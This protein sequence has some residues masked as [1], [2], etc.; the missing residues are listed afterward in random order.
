MRFGELFGM[1]REAAPAT[2]ARAFATTGSGCGRATELHLTDEA[3]EVA[4]AI[5]FE[6]PL[7]RYLHPQREVHNLILT[8]TLHAAGAQ[9]VRPALD[10]AA[11]RRLRGARARPARGP[12]GDPARGF[13]EGANTASFEL[14]AATEKRLVA[15]G[16]AT[17]PS[18]V[19]AA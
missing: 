2:Y 6:I 19:A 7:P 1:P 14:V 17:L 12:A 18:S 3:R 4:L 10:A 15:G 13:A 5:A 11:R 9:A 16:K 8:G